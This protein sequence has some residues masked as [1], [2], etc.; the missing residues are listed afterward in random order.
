MTRITGGL[1]FNSK[2]GIRQG[3]EVP[4]SLPV[5]SNYHVVNNR[6]TIIGDL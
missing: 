2:G 6:Q 5:K 3:H 1:D 4:Q